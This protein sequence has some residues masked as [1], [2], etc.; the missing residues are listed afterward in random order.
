MDRKIYIFGDSFSAPFDLNVNKDIWFS[1][2]CDFIGRTPKMFG[3]FLN[4]ELDFEVVNLARGGND[5]YTILETIINSLDKIIA[6]DL[7]IIGWSSINRFRLANSKNEFEPIINSK[8]IT[9]NMKIPKDVIN[10]ILVNR[11]AKPYKD[12]LNSF[13]TL[14]NHLFRHN[15]L[16]QWSIFYNSHYHGI[17]VMGVPDKCTTVSKETNFAVKDAHFSE[18]G[19]KELAYFFLGKIFPVPEQAPEVPIVPDEIKEITWISKKLI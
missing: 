2:Y 14:C 18:E 3:D 7:V 10:E 19:H 5:N 6:G 8:T 9:K 13:I 17:N 12:E 11:E 16:I 4:Y 15:I 1:K